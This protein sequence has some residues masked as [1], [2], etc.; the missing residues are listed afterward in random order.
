MTSAQGSYWQEG[1]LTEANGAAN[2]TVNEATEY[3]EWLG[4]GGTFNEAGWHALAEVD[5]S[6][7][8]RAI[9]L[10]FD[11]QDGA[12]FV[13]GRIPMG[14][15]DYAVERYTLNDTPNDTAMTNFS[16]E[17][18]RMYLIPYIK[19][20]LE[21]NPNLRLWG[22]PWTPPA[23]M[24]T[25]NDLNG[26]KEGETAEATFKNEPGA[27]SALALYFALFVEKYA[28][29]EGIDVEAV[30][31]QNE[32]G[33]ATRYPSC[34]W[35][36]SVLRDFIRDHLGPTFTSRNVDAEIWLGTMSAPEDV[37]HVQTVMAD[38]AARA[39]VKGIGLQWNTMGSVGTF[40]S[41]YQV[42]VMQTEHRC[43]N[44]PFTVPNTPAFNPDQPPN[45]HAY[46]VESW[47]YI[48]DWIKAGVNVYSAWNMV[49]DTKG[50]NSDY[51]RPWPQNALLTVDRTTKTL[52]VTPAYYTF[53]HVSQFVDAGA[54]RVAV[55]GSE[56]ALAFKNPDGGI[57][58]VVHN[59]GG[60]AQQI[61]LAAGGRTVQFSVP[62]NGWATANIEVP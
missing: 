52:N 31:P 62:A 7:R 27:L 16:I 36:P 61:T 17:R 45:D 20:A 12:N 10:L 46:A 56:E 24:K 53:R 49:L 32:P 48:R 19:A 44:Y 22:S 6:E 50:H 40:A 42:P 28:E 38:N 59:S 21:L 18:D 15:S 23:W 43:G 51:Q 47:W 41:Q 3:Q 2:L 11:A 34:L 33:Y 57:V 54:K 4:F 35:E 30:Q 25:N 5:A 55:T 39:Y 60:Q 13:F 8:A 14:A 1:Q 29:E 26:I 9:E 58:T 37:M